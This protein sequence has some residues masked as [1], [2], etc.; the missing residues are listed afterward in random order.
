MKKLIVLSFCALLLS[1]CKNHKQTRMPYYNSADFTPLWLN[2][3]DPQYKTL[4]IIPPFAFTDQDGRTISQHTTDGKIYVVNF[5]FTRCSNICPRMT[6]NMHMAA[7]SFAHDNRVLFISHSVTPWY[8]SVAVLKKYAQ[9]KHITNPNWHLVTGDQQQIYTIARKGYFADAQANI[10]TTQFL[11][12][13]NF[14]LVDGQRHIRGI[15]N[16]TIPFEVNNMV[17]QIKELEKED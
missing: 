2:K 11:H 1:A 6:E 9:A 5:F 8:D 16:G 13:E 12:T 3:T 4:H 17:K 10:A 15:Y 7:D 14:I